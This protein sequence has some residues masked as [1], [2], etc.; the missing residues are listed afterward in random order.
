M[1]ERITP[2]MAG[3]P[4]S[5]IKRYIDYLNDNFYSTHSILML[6]DGKIFTEAYWHPFDKDF[7][8]R[9]Y[10]QTKSFVGIAIGMLV[11]E[12]KLSLDDKIADLFPEKIDD[13]NAVSERLKRQTVRQMLTMTTVGEPKWWFDQTDPDRTHIYFNNRTGTKIPGAFWEYDSAGSQVLSSLVEKLTGMSLFDF[14]Y[15]RLFSHMGTFKTASILKTK[16]GDSWGD[17]AMLCTARDMAS[18]AQLLLNEGCWD[19]KQLID[20]AYVREATSKIVDNSE[21][22]DG[23]VF[24]HGYGYQIWRTARDGFAFVGMG[25]QLTVT[26]P[27]KRLIFVINSDNQGNASAY[28][29]IINGFF[30]FIVDRISDN[31]LPDAPDECAELENVINRLELFAL[32]GISNRQLI[33]RINNITYVCE[34]NQLGMTK[35]SFTF[36]GER[37]EFRYTNAQGEKTL[38]FG[39]N[40][41]VFGKF[42]EFG[43][44]DEIGGEVTTNGHTYSDAV[45]LR[46]TEGSKLQMKIQIIDK[47]L[48]NFLASFAFVGDE[49]AC[50]FTGTAENFLQSYN[51]SFVAKRKE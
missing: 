27:S 11:S 40:K 42:P 10:S 50:K 41:N 1:F 17:S 16:N 33:E 7:C 44:S 19:G 37:G 36:D 20:A 32:K 47:Y 35:F 51:G 29:I 24:G 8:H 5:E 43:Y 4:S 2:E 30:S 6:R 26:I 18:F 15:E 45:S 38:P 22:K 48:G 39:I 25:C 23:H 13:E 12:G 21:E 28:D 9:Q 49:V 34:P 31:P 46:F 14:L 3:V